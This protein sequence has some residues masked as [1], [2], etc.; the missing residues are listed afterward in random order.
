ME[1]L[2]IVPD[3]DVVEDHQPDL[4]AGGQGREGTLGFERA[5]KVLHGGI[6]KQWPTPLMLTWMWWVASRFWIRALVY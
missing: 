4:G 3:F 5:D 2:A 1:T 6:V